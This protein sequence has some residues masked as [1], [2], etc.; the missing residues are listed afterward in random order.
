MRVGPAGVFLGCFDPHGRRDGT[1]TARLLTRAMDGAASVWSIAP[2]L[3]IAVSDSLGEPSRPLLMVDGTIRPTGAQPAEDIYDLLT[4]EGLWQAYERE[5]EQALARIRG[6]F[7]LLIYDAGCHRGLLA[8]DPLGLR[9]VFLV[10][11][12]GC[13]LFASEIKPLLAALPSRPAPDDVTFAHWLGMANLREPRTLFSDVRRLPPGHALRLEP[14]GWT[15][16]RYWHWRYEPDLGGSEA[17]LIEGLLN[18]VERSTALSLCSARSPALQLSGGLDSS[19]V[20]SCADAVRPGALRTYSAVF[21]HHP[22]T[23]ESPL[24]ELQ[25]RRFGLHGLMLEVHG[26]SV[27]GGTL[28]Y[29]Q[30]WGLPDISS[31]SFFFAPLLKRIADDGVDLLLDGEGGDELFATSAYLLADLLRAGRPISM[32]ALVRRIRGIGR[33][34]TR[35]EL[36]VR[37]GLLGALPARAARALHP[38]LGGHVELPDHLNAATRSSIEQRADLDAWKRSGDPRWWSFLVDELAGGGETMGAAE[39]H[40]RLTRPWGLAKRHPLLDLDLVL[41]VLRL[42]AELS[43][44]RSFSRPLQRRAFAGRIPEEILKRAHKSYF[45]SIR[46]DSLRGPDLPLVRE[47]LLAPDAQIRRYTRPERVCE[48]IERPPSSAEDASWGAQVMQLLTG[49]CWLRQQA[50]QDFAAKMLEHPMLQEPR[51]RWRASGLES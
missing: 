7:A 36:L 10:E 20:L 1:E 29:L 5:G 26:G 27:L 46:S 18:Q 31:N 49:E 6:E 14:D 47:L 48:L 23:D 51:L 33:R 30:E 45:D 40:L 39:H 25:Q 3:T 37:Y 50:D 19:A 9:P 17:D 44:D 32:L 12:G 4:A 41:S 2:S 28:R 11:I 34:R 21:P 43:F 13:L 22:Q 42:P 16:T 35:I 24:I 38:L 15:Q 8:R